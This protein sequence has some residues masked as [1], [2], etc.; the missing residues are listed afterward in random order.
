[1]TTRSRKA[2]AAYKASL[3]P[4]ALAAFEANERTIRAERI[5]RRKAARAAMGTNWSKGRKLDREALRHHRETLCAGRYDAHPH[6]APDTCAYCANPVK[7]TNR[8]HVPPVSLLAYQDG[9][10]LLVPCCPP[11]NTNIS[12]SPA[13]CLKARAATA[14]SRRKRAAW[15]AEEHQARFDRIAARIALGDIAATCTCDRCSAAK[16]QP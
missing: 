6:A 16:R 3:A 7:Q 8:D 13:T 14:L 2:R 5:A 11:C 10:G 12:S 15:Q 1:M 9:T 4:E